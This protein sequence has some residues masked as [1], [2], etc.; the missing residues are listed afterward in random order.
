MDSESTGV[1]KYQLGF[2]L[3]DYNFDKEGRKIYKKNKFMR[4]LTN[5]MENP[6][7][8]EIFDKYFDCWDNIEIFTMFAKVYNSITKKIPDLN[9]YEKIAIVK[10]IIDTSE[11]RQIVCQ[12]IKNFRKDKSLIALKLQKPNKKIVNLEYD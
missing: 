5:V 4:S 12:E 1:N 11:T 2:S 6:E 8:L 10:K 9:G 3:N 7:F